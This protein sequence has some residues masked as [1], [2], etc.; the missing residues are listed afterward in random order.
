MKNFFTDK[1]GK[2]VIMQMPNVPILTWGS[3]RLLMLVPAFSGVSELLSMIAFGAL[4]TWA[5]LEI[6]SGVNV[7]RRSL[8][9]VVMVVLLSGT[10]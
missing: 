1:D 10:L 3:A 6:C 7:F 2:I 5:W 8:G 9:V 4:F